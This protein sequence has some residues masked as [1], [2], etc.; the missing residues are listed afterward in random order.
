M[1]KNDTQRLDV[2]R[3]AS[4]FFPTLNPYSDV[5]VLCVAPTGLLK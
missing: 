5:R 4:R 2:V 1:E 3:L